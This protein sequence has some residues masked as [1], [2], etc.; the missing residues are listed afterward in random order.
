MSFKNTLSKSTKRLPDSKLPHIISIS[1]IIPNYKGK[2]IETY[3]NIDFD[4]NKKKDTT[5]GIIAEI[6]EHSKGIGFPF[7]SN[8]Q[9]KIL[10]ENFDKL[11][12]T[13]QQS[14]FYKISF[15]ET[16]KNFDLAIVKGKS[17]KKVSVKKIFKTPHRLSGTNSFGRQIKKKRSNKKK[18]R[19]PLFQSLKYQKRIAGL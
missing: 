5:K 10:K 11:L 6:K 15:K 16:D 3:T 7:V 18:K 14:I 4:F 12:A 17:I 2:L 8:D 1:L 9:L 19:S 13:N